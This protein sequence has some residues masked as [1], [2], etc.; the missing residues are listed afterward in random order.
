MVLQNQNVQLS[1]RLREYQ[2]PEGGFV[3]IPDT[4]LRRLQ[5]QDALLEQSDTEVREIGKL[6]AHLQ[7]TVE[8]L[9]EG[10]VGEMV[11]NY[12]LYPTLW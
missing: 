9:R 6:N 1:Q 3:K 4:E 12:S 7:G 10:K 5:A 2:N 8:E 11:L